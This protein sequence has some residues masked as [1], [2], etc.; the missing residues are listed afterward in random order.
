MVPDLKLG[1]AGKKRMGN[2]LDGGGRADGTVRREMLL[3]DA[4]VEDGSGGD[5]VI[6]GP[7]PDRTSSQR[8]RNCP[9]GT[10]LRGTERRERQGGGRNRIEQFLEVSN[11][12]ERQSSATGGGWRRRKQKTATERTQGGRL[13]NIR[14]RTRR[15]EALL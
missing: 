2:V 15:D 4:V 9:E 6:D 11:A 3:W 8:N 5:L 13:R 1:R 14:R 12:V 10:P 7:V